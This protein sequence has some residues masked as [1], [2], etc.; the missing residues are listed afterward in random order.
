MYCKCI[1]HYWKAQGNNWYGR[2]GLP[3]AHG[4]EEAMNTRKFED[5]DMLRDKVL[6]SPVPESHAYCTEWYERYRNYYIIYGLIIPLIM[7]IVNQV[8]AKLMSIFAIMEKH[9]EIGQE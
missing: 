4:M 9:H 2:A 6:F 8:T 3:W 5:V 1:P 7:L